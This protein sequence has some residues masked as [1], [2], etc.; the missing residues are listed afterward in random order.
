[1]KRNKEMILLDQLHA[2]VL[3]IIMTVVLVVLGIL[4]LASSDCPKFMMPAAV[5]MLQTESITEASGIIAS[6]INSGVFWIHED[7]GAEAKIYAIDLAGKLLATRTLSNV[8][9]ID[10][11][12]IAI[13]AR[14]SGESY[15]Y[16]ADIGDNNFHRKNIIVYRFPEPSLEP[17]ASDGTIEASNIETF[18]LVYPDRPH[19]AET[20]L[21][22]PLSGDVYVVTKWES[23]SRIYRAR[24]KDQR[25]TAL[26][27]YVGHLP[28]SGAT[29][30]D[31]SRDG[32]SIIIRT[33]FAAY[34]WIR[35]SKAPLENTIESEGCQV[36]IAMEPQGEA[37]CFSSD[38][39][40]FVTI[41]EGLHPHIYETVRGPR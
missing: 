8:H 12:D 1:M 14:P 36:S 15:L 5:G 10:W 22:D 32:R 9:A 4:V 17:D 21:V 6:M 29:G 2:S 13:A 27:E 23:Q 18:R 41:S 19:D 34:V 11:E 31:V 7:S 33:Y 24:L 35:D 26:L 28:F 39:G 20:L 30:G 16:V 3:T 40:A 37:V 38:G 25:K